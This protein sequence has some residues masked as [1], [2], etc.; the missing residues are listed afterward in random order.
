VLRH[1]KDESRHSRLFLELSRVAFPTAVDDSLVQRLDE[2]LP[3]VRR[4]TPQKSAVRI[5][6]E[7][8]IDHLVQMNIGEIRTRI[9]VQ[10]L[11]PV[12]HALAPPEGRRRV[13]QILDGLVLD[14]VRHIGYTARLMERW[15]SSGDAQLVRDLYAERLQDFHRITIE[16][17]E[18]AVRAYGQGRFP[19][20]LEI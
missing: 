13:R 18:S 12:V 7:L 11:A 19:E 5:P 16:E 9:H 8:L 20:L 17:T 4:R 2:A 14:E 15:A 1:A 6:G 3:D 10:L